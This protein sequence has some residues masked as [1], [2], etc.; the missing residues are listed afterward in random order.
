MPRELSSAVN[1]VNL[2]FGAP[3]ENA[4]HEDRLSK[5][6]TLIEAAIDLDRIPDDYM[7][8]ASYDANLEARA[9][10]HISSELCTFIHMLTV[11]TS[12]CVAC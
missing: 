6:E 1:A 3:L 12:Y 8:C 10:L 9:C 2:R 4:H 7:I 11:S 5:F